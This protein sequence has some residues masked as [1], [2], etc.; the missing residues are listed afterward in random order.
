LVRIAKNEYIF[1]N[2]DE[3]MLISDYSPKEIIFF[4]NQGKSKILGV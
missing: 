1:N 3:N 4:T 2:I